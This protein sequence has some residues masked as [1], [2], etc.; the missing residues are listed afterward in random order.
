MSD[1]VAQLQQEPDAVLPQFRNDVLEGLSRTP[2]ALPAKYF[3]D[4][5]GSLL[6]EQ[7]TRLPEY[8]PTRTEL[9]ILQSQGAGIGALCP[10]RAALVEFGS[11]STVKMRCLLPHLPDLAAY[12]PVDVSVDFMSTE[13][14]QLRSDEPGLDVVP[15][16]PISP[17]LRS[18]D[19]LAGR[20]AVGFFPGSTIGN[21]EP[22]EAELLLATFAGLLGR[23]ALL[24]IGV[25]L[26][27]EV[28]VLESAYNDARASRHSST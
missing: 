7:I 22:G 12:V 21:F 11:G 19:E 15:V 4:L 24:I 13:V 10:P 8:Y 14:A 26:V 20:P 27:K 23:E 1:D 2:K 3:Y 16:R 17:A 28:A 9:G 5:Q 18:S 25:D 6:F